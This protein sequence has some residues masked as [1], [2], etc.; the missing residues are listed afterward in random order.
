MSQEPEYDEVTDTY[1]TGHEWDGIKELDTPMPRW[2]LW[3][4]YACIVWAI[5][6]WIAMPA[7]PMV[8]DY[9]KGMLGYSQR[10]VVKAQLDSVKAD[11]KISAE[12]LLDADL[13]T[14]K[15]TPALLEFAL[16]GGKAAFGDNC[17]ACHGTGA[18][19]TKGYPNLNDDD[20][21]WGGSLDEIHHTL[22][23]G[24]R[25]V[26]E[27]TRISDMPAFLKD[28]ILDKSQIRAVA[29]YVKSLS[30]SSISAPENGAV[31]FQENCAACHGADGKGSRDFGAPNLADGIWLYGDD[32]DSLIATISYSRKGVMPSWENRLDAA[33]IKSLAIYVHTLGGGE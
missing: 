32:M 19:G 7:W 14:I 3:T 30:D 2:W 20:W 13:E 26:H 27:D 10:D 1:T 24:V 5:G 12:K 29:T 25:A 6:Y 23:V 4:F 17:A 22:T 16:A 31:L 9:T 8:S 28:E 18:S 15:N 11:R 21:L 33:T